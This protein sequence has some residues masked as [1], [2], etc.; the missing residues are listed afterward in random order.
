MPS[1][2]LDGGKF[3]NVCNICYKDSNAH[4]VPKGTRLSIFSVAFSGIH[5]IGK[6]Q[7]LNINVRF[8]SL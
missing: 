4:V 8:V 3:S 1:Q 7:V 6:L 2:T 5:I